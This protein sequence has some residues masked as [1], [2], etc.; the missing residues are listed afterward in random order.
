[1]DDSL[2]NKYK[3]IRGQIE[4]NYPKLNKLTIGNDYYLPPDG[5][6]GRDGAAV[7]TNTHIKELRFYLMHVYLMHDRVRRDELEAFCGG[8]PAI[9]PSRSCA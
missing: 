1:M 2:V 4:S 9:S 6:W 5:D 8:W 3:K 7:G